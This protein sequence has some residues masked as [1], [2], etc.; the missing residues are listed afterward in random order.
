M[1]N[2]KLIPCRKCGTPFDPR[3]DF[4]RLHP[5]DTCDNCVPDPFTPEQLEKIVS[6]FAAARSRR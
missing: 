4:S 2:E 3:P 6:A 5:T 1:M